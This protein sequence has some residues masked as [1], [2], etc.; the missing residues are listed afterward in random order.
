MVKEISLKISSKFLPKRNDKGNKKS[1]GSVLVCGGSFNMSGAVYFTSLAS[2]RAGCGLVY[3]FVPSSIKDVISCL[4][5]E[6]IVFCGSEKNFLVRDYDIFFDIVKRIKPDIVV[7]G[8]G[9][10]REKETVSFLVSVLKDITV[11]FILDA[12]ALYAITQSNN[13]RFLKNKLSILT[14][15]TG[16]AKRFYDLNDNEKLAVKISNETNSIVVLKDYKTFVTDGNDVYVLNRPNSALSKAGSGDI[17][18]GIIASIFVQK[19]KNSGFD[20]N[21]ALYSSVCGVYIHSLCGRLILKKMNSYGVIAS[22]LIDEIPNAIGLLK[23]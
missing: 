17:L 9:M 13:F 21:V 12:D 1:F 18:A 3:I 11:P 10:G 14:P 4:L 7:F 2:L 15:H 6:S 16:E 20:K 5:P 22:D 19:G 8:P 23:R